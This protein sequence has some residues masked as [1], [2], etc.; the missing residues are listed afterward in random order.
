MCEWLNLKHNKEF[1][2]IQNTTEKV[3]MYCVIHHR[4]YDEIF[5]YIGIN[6]VNPIYEGQS[7]N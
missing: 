5:D 4:M 7:K 2:N 1:F 3:Q 6:Q